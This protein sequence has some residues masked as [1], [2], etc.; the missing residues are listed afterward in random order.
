LREYVEASKSIP[1]E[2]VSVGNCPS[3]PMRAL[4]AELLG[5]DQ[6]VQRRGRGR[7][8]RIAGDAPAAEQAE[9]NAAWL[10]A[11]RLKA[12]CRRHG[13]ERAPPAVKKKVIS[14]ACYQVAKEFGV[15]PDTIKE[16]NVLNLL[17]SGRIVVA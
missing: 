13:R 11:Y 12:W 10:I 16:R 8:F 14:R 3:K 9:R 4:V 17:K 5:N 1:E 15:L 2:T 7:P 6:P